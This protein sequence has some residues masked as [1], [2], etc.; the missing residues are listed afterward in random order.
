[1]K[2]HLPRFVC[3]SLGA[4]LVTTSLLLT[5]CDDQSEDTGPELRP[6]RYVI[7]D[8]PMTVRTRTL[9]GS[10][11]SAQESRISFKVPGTVVNIPVQVGDT[12]EKGGLVASLDPSQYELRVQQS[13]A[14]LLQSQASARNEQANYER[15]KELYENSNASRNDLDS[16]RA[17]AES[18]E[19]QVRAA[20]KSLELA[21]LDLSDT[22]LRAEQDC[23]IAELMVET[24]ENV[25]AGT[26]IAQVNCGD[27]LEVI[28]DVPEGMIADIGQRMPV[29][30]RF[31]A[32][33]GKNFQG[34]VLEIGVSA[35]DTSTTFP[36]SIRL[37]GID[38]ELRSGLAA[39]VVFSFALEKG[40]DRYLVPLAAVVNDV[41]GAFVFVAEPDSQPGEAV[42]RRNTV[43]LGDLTDG[44]MEIVSGIEKGDRVITAGV[45]VIREGQRVLLP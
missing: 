25:A 15:I 28:I 4:A 43:Q 37:Y 24:N 35:S 42:V 39:E 12:L 3:V 41:E 30:V 40:R 34:Q 27:E 9:T 5:G 31:D 29:V 19:A 14:S 7:V 16:A 11:K 33:P 44:G 23:S 8:K 26:H 36:V 22:R 2:L 1:M 21:Q 18:A 20:Q 32:L 45:S 10:S 13:Q 6:V 17:S 38:P